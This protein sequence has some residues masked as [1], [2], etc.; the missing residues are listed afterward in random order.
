MNLIPS[1]DNLKPTSGANGVHK[2]LTL[3]FEGQ[4]V[5]FIIRDGVPFD[6]APAW[7]RAD[8]AEALGFKNPEQVGKS[9]LVE[10][11]DKG[12]N[13]ILTLG[14]AQS[15]GVLTYTGLTKLLMRSDKETARRFQDWLAA[16]SSDLTKPAAQS[17]GPPA[18]QNS[19]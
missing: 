17:P 4:P 13:R 2:P 9:F 19:V 6:L 5:R 1:G 15:V 11:V 18:E 8:V 10:G 7:V 12:Q 16:K 14:G 3:Y